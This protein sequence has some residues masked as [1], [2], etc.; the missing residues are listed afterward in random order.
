MSDA[1]VISIIGA[2]AGV[3][4]AIISGYS[5]YKIAGIHKQLNSMRDQEN[6]T[7]RDLGNAEGKAE[8]K[9]KQSL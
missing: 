5:A 2:I 3:S 9:A 8:E 6:K 1:V 7:N 4:A